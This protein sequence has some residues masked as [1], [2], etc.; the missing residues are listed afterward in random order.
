QREPGRALPQAVREHLARPIEQRE[1][2]RAV[3]EGG[4]YAGRPR[5]AEPRERALQ[6]LC[7][8]AVD[9]LVQLLALRQ[10][11]VRGARRLLRQDHRD[12]IERGELRLGE[13][14]RCLCDF[15]WCEIRKIE[16]SC[17]LD[18]CWANADHSAAREGTIQDRA[19]I[20]AGA[21]REFI[22]KA[23]NYRVSS[24][25]RPW[26]PHD[27][28]RRSGRPKTTWIPRKLKSGSSRSIR[29]FACTAPSARIICSS[30]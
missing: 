12:V 15:K 23:L 20:V 13:C 16:H 10:I 29:F 25:R 2:G 19:R 5:V 22:G 28:C 27:L 21:P 7:P 9:Q 18:P 1:R 26:R 6:A 14:A 24:R 11:R 17:C 30:A 3:E 4:R 8:S